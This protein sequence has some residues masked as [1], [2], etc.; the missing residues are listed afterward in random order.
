MRRGVV[1][2]LVALGAAL[3]VLAGCALP[4]QTRALADAPPGGVPV[5]TELASVPFF[6]QTEY[7][8]GPAALATALG[9]AGF[10]VQPDDLAPQVYLPAR[11]GSLQ[12]EMLA[13]ARR[14]GALAVRLPP[15]L[16]AVLDELAAGHPVVVLQN[17]GLSFAPGWHYAV[18][19]G[20][21]LEAGTLLLRSG[22]VERQ[23]LS[24]AT[25]EN[26]WARGGHWAFVALPPGRLPA[27]ATENE[28]VAA[29]VALER[30]VP[31]AIARRAYDAALAQWPGNL[32]L[33]VG[34]GNARHAGGDLAGAAEVFEAAAALHDSAPAWINLAAVRLEQGQ[35]KAAEGAA[36]RAVARAAGD[37]VWQGPADEVLAKVLAARP[38]AAKRRARTVRD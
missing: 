26:T 36:R 33:A 10:A 6:P 20:H 13:G 29:T 7:H 15:S 21:D 12:I 3:L 4:P 1:A 18:V 14:Q 16:R 23:V 17:L 25:F 34:A 24:L 2:R 22:T 31:P 32:T 11:Q 30:S 35:S 9:A 5:R 19:V 28:V 37:P 38:A 27:A 8:C